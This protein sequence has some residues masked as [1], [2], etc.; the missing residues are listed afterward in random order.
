MRKVANVADPVCE[1]TRVMIYDPGDRQVVYLYLRS[2]D[3]GPC[4]SD[5][6]Y[7]TVADAEEVVLSASEFC[8]PIG[9]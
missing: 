4:A 7:Y 3:D 2:A 5:L 8:R 1:S 9:C 6:Y